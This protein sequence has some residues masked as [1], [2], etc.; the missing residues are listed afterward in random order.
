MRFFG[1]AVLFC[2]GLIFAI[3]AGF[4]TLAVGTLVE[5]AAREI[6]TEL[7]LA[8][9]DAV[10]SE[11]GHGGPAAFDA[12]GLLAGMWALSAALLFLPPAFVALVGEIAGFRSFAW[13]GFGTGLFTAALPWL[14]RGWER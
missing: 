5:P 10:L 2:L 9:A 3:P 11:L 14:G 7:G 1:R 4:M 6:V 12:A 13:Y 8:G